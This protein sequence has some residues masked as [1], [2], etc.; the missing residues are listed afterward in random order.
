MEEFIV[1]KNSV[2]IG[3]GYLQHA[4][5]SSKESHLLGRDT[6]FVPEAATLKDGVAFVF[7]ASAGWKAGLPGNDRW[8]LG[9]M[10]NLKHVMELVLEWKRW[11]P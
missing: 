8:D 6:N 10:K 9:R 4:G 11:R 5:I 2:L 1:P 3:Y 7:A